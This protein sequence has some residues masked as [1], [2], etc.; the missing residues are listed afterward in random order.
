M[1]G[2]FGKKYPEPAQPQTSEQPG[3]PLGAYAPVVADKMLDT[4]L[5]S[6][7]GEEMAREREG[8]SNQTTDM[9]K[10]IGQRIIRELL[11]KSNDKDEAI[12]L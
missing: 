10:R 8:K 6:S 4:A 5:L 12:G 1:F 7:I 3:N 2:W 11:D 9:G